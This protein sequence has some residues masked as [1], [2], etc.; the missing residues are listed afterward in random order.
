MSGRNCRRWRPPCPDLING[1][2]KRVPPRSAAPS[3]WGKGYGNGKEGLESAP[4][5]CFGIIRMFAGGKWE[6]GLTRV[7]ALIIVRRLGNGNLA[8]S[9]VTFPGIVGSG[10]GLGLGLG[11]GRGL[12][13][14]LVVF[15]FI[16]VLFLNLLLPS[17]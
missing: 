3:S 11:L 6:T 2:A 14:L 8:V 16:L 4:L 1:K 5:L 17:A 7:F 9:A 15:P 12:L 10:L 13:L